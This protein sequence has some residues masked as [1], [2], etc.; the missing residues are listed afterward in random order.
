MLNL[1]KAV[2][3]KHKLFF[4]LFFHTF[5]DLH[6]EKTLQKIKLQQNVHLNVVCVY[7]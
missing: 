7:M 2:D 4:C 1:P 3:K 6:V 5:C